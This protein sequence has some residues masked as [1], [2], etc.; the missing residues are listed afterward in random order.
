MQIHIS[1]HISVFEEILAALL[2]FAYLHLHIAHSI[3]V[4]K[5]RFLSFR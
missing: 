4:N 3:F 1:T 2:L 5:T